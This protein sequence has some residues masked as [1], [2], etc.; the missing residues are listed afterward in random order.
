MAWPNQ[1][2][3]TFGQLDSGIYLTCLLVAVSDRKRCRLR[4][5]FDV[6]GHGHGRSVRSPPGLGR[7]VEQDSVG[8]VAD[9]PLAKRHIALVVGPHLRRLDLQTLSQPAAIKLLDVE[10]R[11][12]TSHEPRPVVESPAAQLQSDEH[13]GAGIIAPAPPP[14]RLDRRIGVTSFVGGSEQHLDPAD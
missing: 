4:S 7:I 1:L 11:L 10:E 8:F 9:A 14:P 6:E 12:T 2:E 5:P 3:H 13:T